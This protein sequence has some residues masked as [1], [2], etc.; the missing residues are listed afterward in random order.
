LRKLERIVHV[1]GTKKIAQLL[2]L[3]GQEG[4]FISVIDGNKDNN[5]LEKYSVV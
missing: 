4:Q 3:K 5:Y 1:I 2:I